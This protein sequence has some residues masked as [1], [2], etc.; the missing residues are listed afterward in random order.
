M[1]N[2]SLNIPSREV[3]LLL[4]FQGVLDDWNTVIPFEVCTARPTA[5]DGATFNSESPGESYFT[6]G[7][8]LVFWGVLFA[9][10]TFPETFFIV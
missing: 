1:P 5:E 9:Q 6:E 10:T 8:A 7:K 3:S 4:T 2:I